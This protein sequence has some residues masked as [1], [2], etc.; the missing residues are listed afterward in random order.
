VVSARAEEE[1]EP[2]IVEPSKAG[3]FCVAFD[4]LDGSSV[5]ARP[6]RLSGLSMFH[7]ESVLYV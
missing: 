1:E 6:G 3:R 5:R 2:I 4:P 7:N